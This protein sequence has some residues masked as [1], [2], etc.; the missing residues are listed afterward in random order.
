MEEEKNII[1]EVLINKNMIKMDNIYI[2][3]KLQ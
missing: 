1:D 2:Y 3:V